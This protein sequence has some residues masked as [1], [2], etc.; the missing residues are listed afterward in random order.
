MTKVLNFI[1]DPRFISFVGL[2]ALSIL[3]W[4]GGPY[5]RFGENNYA[6]LASEITRL[7]FVIFILMLWGLNNL[8]H[9]YV[10]NKKND[11][12]IS[13]LEEDNNQSSND[14]IQ[15][16]EELKVINERFTNALDTLKKLRVKGKF[17]KSKAIYELPWYIIIGPPGSGKTTAL[18]N[19]GL[20]FPLS[21]QIG[22]ASLQGVGGTRNCDWWFTN[23]AV[24]IDT[25]GRYTT[26]D[27]HRGIDSSAWNGFLKLLKRNRPRRPINGAIIAISVQ[28]LLLQTEEERSWHAKTV[29]N[30]IDELTSQL[31]VRFPVYIMLTKS[32]LIAGF[33]E[34]FNDYGHYDR[35][36]VCGITFPGGERQAT[37]F[38]WWSGEYDS[39]VARMFDRVL[40]R[41]HQER[42]IKR[43]TKIQTFPQEVAN[44]K[45]SIETFLRQ[46]FS[47]SRYHEKPYLRGVYFSSGTQDGTPIDR[48]M[49][50][51]SS[52]YGMSADVAPAVPGQGKSYFIGRLFKELIFSESELVGTNKKAEKFYTYGRKGAYIAL[53]SVFVGSLVAW[54]GSV[55][56]NKLL[57]D[58]I[59]AYLT[60]YENENRRIKSWNTDL[61]RVLPTLNAIHV[62][63]QVY[64]Q[65]EHPWLN[66]LG[67]YDS[68]VDNS[69]NKLYLQN[70]KQWFE[71]RVVKYLEQDL[72]ASLNQ[73]GQLY[74]S[75]KTY[76]MFEDEVHFDKEH[77]KD[78]FKQSWKHQFSQK[79][80]VQR[81]LNT[82]LVAYLDN[83]SQSI[84]LD[85]ALIN[86]AQNKLMR[87]PVATRVYE[88]IKSNKQL[89]TMVNVGNY[90]GEA[91]QDIFNY[92]NNSLSG[93]SIPYLFTKNAYD[94]LDFTADSPH[95]H[96][97]LSD[98]WVLSP[99]KRS[100]QYEKNY[101]Y[102][103][104][105]LEEIG[106]KVKALYLT[107]YAHHWQKALQ[108]LSLKRFS[109]L[110]VASKRLSE[111]SDAV[112]SPISRMLEVAHANT[113]LSPYVPVDI[114]GASDKSAKGKLV[115]GLGSMVA[116]V[117]EGN[118]VDK[119]FRKLN[120][121]NRESKNKPA[122]IGTTL[123]LLNE[124]FS[125][126]NEVL[127]SPDPKEAAYKAAKARFSGAGSDVFR[128]IQVHAAG[129]P[130]PV[131]Q[132][133]LQLSRQSWAVVLAS[134][135]SHIQ[136]QWRV[137]VL[138]AY[139]A[140]IQ[141]K[142]PIYGQASSELELYDFTEFFKPEGT[143]KKFMNQHL[144]PFIKKGTK[145][146]LK[147]VD[148]QTIGLSRSTVSQLQ[149]GNLISQVFFKTNPEKPSFQFQTRPAKMLK[150]VSRFVLDMGGN[151]YS[152]THG[153]KFWSNHAWPGGID[154][155][156]VSIYFEKLDNEIL[157]RDYDGA[158]SWFRLLDQ[159]RLSATQQPN[160]FN[161]IYSMADSEARYEIKANSV[162]NP[163][164]KGLLSNFRCPRTL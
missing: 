78:W 97:I 147:K 160:R 53:L 86:A 123:V 141:G 96:E 163:F 124:L 55:A 136:Q 76:L 155:Q 143:Y 92:N 2:L 3:I 105:Q 127:I 9:Q 83:Y 154:A 125:Y 85:Q 91:S 151:K 114:P 6:P 51:I 32:D 12:L 162:V 30:R 4:F 35:E 18:V 129:L 21:D 88:R 65:D 23:E 8:R 64:D 1:K 52:N 36:D 122:P 103:D 157:T 40:G 24:M 82:H 43:R 93:F 39:M 74:N 130:A 87:I 45:S 131:G 99:K 63:S 58:E 139:K 67:L 138:N 68:G 54:T 26:Q 149:R 98:D 100:A 137:Q 111:L 73:P 128:K 140:G 44:L 153:P 121:L 66:N 126:V 161:V 37:D 102:D 11:E 94:E 110:G 77:L 69:L 31:G 142:Y 89:S 118:K 13:D 150:S 134:A 109:S 95:L 108:G 158:W 104:S 5:I 133:V 116:S 22:S 19:S 119:Q 20:E 47:S 60:K 75:L 146:S 15:S 38:D 107:D 33:T 156:R 48:L 25:A 117:M 101:H 79:E 50:S 14:S 42:D 70:L 7:F 152:Y 46:T 84:D 159:S 106:S 10:A 112:Y 90:L 49:S 80:V 62:A 56:S 17:Q 57:L 29:R 132:W 71:P 72:K 144:S 34:F 148:G 135:K 120:N 59:D 81:Q 164:T 145:W 27:S 41:V 16:A 113:E 61:R 28:D 115:A